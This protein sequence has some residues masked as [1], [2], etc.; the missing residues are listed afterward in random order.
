M[1]DTTPTTAHRAELRLT[2]EEAHNLLG[3][4]LEW[5]DVDGTGYR[6][7]G[8]RFASA[9]AAGL[10]RPVAVD[11]VDVDVFARVVRVG[12]AGDWLGPQAVHLEGSDRVRVTLDDLAL[13]PR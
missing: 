12:L 11:A 1:T 4:E 10:G 3:I 9:L 13:L 6:A 2:F 7:L 5:L 8:Y